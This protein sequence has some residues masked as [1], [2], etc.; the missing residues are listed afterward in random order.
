MLIDL[1]ATSPVIVALVFMVFFS[2]LW[3]RRGSKLT[4]VELLLE[5]VEGEYGRVKVALDSLRRDAFEVGRTLTQERDAASGAAHAAAKH[6]ASHA[7]AILAATSKTKGLEDRAV[8]RINP[9]ESIIPEAAAIL[10]LTQSAIRHAINRGNIP[11]RKVLDETR[12]RHAIPNYA[13]ERLKSEM[14]IT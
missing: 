7:A 1:G 8:D 4:K 6:A 5:D 13:I 11:A 14:G 2:L 3:I 12:M 10:G 9:D